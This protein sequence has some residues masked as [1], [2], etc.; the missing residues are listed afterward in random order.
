MLNSPVIDP[1]I[2]EIFGPFKLTW[3]GVLYIS[4]FYLSIRLVENISK[5]TLGLPQGAWRELSGV[6]LI[7]III[8]ARIG[9]MLF[10]HPSLSISNP[11]EIVKIWNG[12][13]SFHGGIIGAIIYLHR[14]SKKY[15][16]PF[17]SVLDAISTTAP[18]AIFFGRIANFINGELYGR[19]TKSALGVIF[20]SSGSM[21]PRHPSQLY[22]AIFEGLIPLII[23]LLLYKRTSMSK[24]AGKLTGT[25]CILYSLASISIENYREPD[26]HIGFI[27]GKFTLGQLLSIPLFCI[28]M[29]L[30]K[31][32]KKS[33]KN[34]SEN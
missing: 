3:Y 21:H 14:I 10:Y 34:Q 30:L 22:E 15:N 19:Y 11:I 17:L 32:S 33:S 13:L 25:W 20:P 28:G 9:Y 1:V 2:I 16:K 29:Y 12:G 8:F 27:I 18:L 7:Y 26:Q 6:M 5:H 24:E 4:G 31:Y 23:M